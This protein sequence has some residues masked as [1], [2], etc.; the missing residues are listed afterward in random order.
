MANS[1]T[2]ALSVI[3]YKYF[4]KMIKIEDTKELLT[5]IQQKNNLRDT[6]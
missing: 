1:L 4:M 3:K 2:K 6:F 5:F